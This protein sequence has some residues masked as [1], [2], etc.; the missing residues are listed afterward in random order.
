[1]P[2]PQKEIEGL[3]GDLE[4]RVDRLRVLYEQYFLG[5][6]KLEPTVPRKEAERRLDVLR[7]EN[8]R[9]TGLRFR[10]QRILQKYNTYQ[11][12]WIRI[13]RQIEEGTF[14]RHVQK[15]KARF[16]DGPRRR[17]EDGLSVEVDLEDLE[18]L[19]ADEVAA[20]T[21]QTAD[22]DDDD[23][24]DTLRPPPPAIPA[25]AFDKL[26]PFDALDALEAPGSRQAPS[27]NFLRTAID[28]HALAVAPPSVPGQP[29]GYRGSAAPLPPGSK[30]RIV[31]RKPG[32]DGMSAPPAGSQVALRGAAPSPGTMRAAPP[33]PQSSRA[34]PPAPAV[35]RAP[36]QPGS[37]AMRAAPP[38]QP[39]S[40]AKRA[41]P[42]AQPG[43]QARAAPPAA[44]AAPP[45]PGD[46]SDDRIRQL[47]SKYIEAK[48]ANRESTAAITFDS[49]AKSLRDST[50]KLK[51]KHG[52][53]NVDFEVTVK[54]GKTIL[55]PVVK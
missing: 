28:P 4:T 36:A 37:Q 10:F 19:D 26:D 39:G 23:N 40:Q 53:K 35:S 27:S 41:A 43:P 46:L 38:A 25:S 7:K 17:D 48:R 44:R 32:P 42:P 20:L 45:K 55:R 30:P 29:A 21:G 18:S 16:A 50:A 33:E 5:F 2:L 22:D 9:N 31:V 8:I 11:T 3:V 14:K 52:G 49:L 13:C 47:Y 6:E 34:A 1:L 51:E 54:D 12:Y 15:A 24:S